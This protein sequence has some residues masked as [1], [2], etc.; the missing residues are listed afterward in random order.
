MRRLAAVTGASGFVGSHVL[1]ALAA[2]GWRL[3]ILARGSPRL[4][5]G[6]ADPVEVVP[7]SLS[8]PAALRALIRGAD[9][10]IHIA[11]SV[12]ARSRA[13]FMAVNA[14]GAESAARVW[15]EVA[16]Q[17]RFVLVS[18]MAAREPGLSDY[19]ASK[20]EGEARI[21]ATADGA[22]YVILRPCAV[23][24]PGDRAT[25]PLF[26]SARLPVQVVPGGDDA[27]LC[28]V[29]VSDLAA[30]VATAPDAPPGCY[31]VSDARTDGY[32]WREIAEALAGRPV[33]TVRAPRPLLRMAGRLG[34]AAGRFGAPAMVGSG[35]IRE[36]LHPDWSS[37]PE[38]QLPASLWRPKVGLAEGFASTLGW[39]REKGWLR[40]RT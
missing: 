39:Y 32:G 7:G 33:A 20:R 24:G 25:L 34:D 29:E 26:R 36:A 10:V 17:A 19:A 12:R 15:R 2:A 28:L 30:A 6:P 9:A 5:F 40:S 14:A 13:E 21:A 23:H 4:D 35:K 37:A 8:E 18:S 11:G 22:A 3:R 16:P 27:R 38:R 1:P 31:E